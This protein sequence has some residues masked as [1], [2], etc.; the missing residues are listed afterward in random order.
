ME[1]TELFVIPIPG[2]NPAKYLHREIYL[3]VREDLSVLNLVDTDDPHQACRVAKVNFPD[4]HVV[5]LTNA[6]EP[7]DCDVVHDLPV[8][9]RRWR[10]DFAIEEG[11]CDWLKQ[12]P[13]GQG[14]N[15]F[16][17]GVAAFLKWQDEI[18]AM[19][20]DFVAQ[21]TGR[22]QSRQIHCDVRM[23]VTGGA[24]PRVHA[25]ASYRPTGDSAAPQSKSFDLTI[26]N[27]P[28]YLVPLFDR[29]FDLQAVPRL[30]VTGPAESI[31]NEDLGTLGMTIASL[32]L[33]PKEPEGARMQLEGAH[34]DL[35]VHVRRV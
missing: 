6:A 20:A 30:D 25:D 3:L 24:R 28:N 7:L 27:E 34:Y 9:A 14:R 15:L 21:V 11:D 32:A 13:I 31:T 29:A 8:W 12:L 4:F 16:F 23:S 17:Q 22:L 35:Q 1:N 26:G 19:Q 10:V 2:A 33:T 5:I 18:A